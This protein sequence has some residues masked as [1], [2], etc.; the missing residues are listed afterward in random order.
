MSSSSGEPIAMF[1]RPVKWCNAEKLILYDTTLEVWKPAIAFPKPAFYD[2]CKLSGRYTYRDGSLLLGALLVAVPVG[3][4][5]VLALWV[6]LHESQTK[7]H[8]EWGTY[9]MLGLFTFAFVVLGYTVVKSARAK[10]R[11]YVF[12][13]KPLL[14]FGASAADANSLHAFATALARQV[15]LEHSGRTYDGGQSHENPLL[16]P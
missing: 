2:L 14:V 9:W 7:G 6:C 8:L 12:E 11:T 3:V 15:L 13:G 16:G 10:S 1:S 5:L 4:I